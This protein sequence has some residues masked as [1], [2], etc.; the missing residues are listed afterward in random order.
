MKK[1]GFKLIYLFVLIC[2]ITASC[3]AG[4]RASGSKNCGC[5]LNKGFI[6]Y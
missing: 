1:S 3:S 6:G 2:L 4:N 5:N